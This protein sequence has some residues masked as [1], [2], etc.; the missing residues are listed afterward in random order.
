MMNTEMKLPTERVE[1]PSKGLI[2]SADNPLR[3]GFVD[4]KYMTAKEEDILTNMNLIENG[5]VLD[6]LLESLTMGKVDIKDLCTGDKN[7]LF[8]AS[9]ILGYGAK[10]KFQYDGDE[11]EVDL[12]KLNNKFINPDLLN[13]QGHFTF[14][15][16]HTQANITFRL[17]NDRDEKNINDEIESLKKL[18]TGGG[19]V[20]TRLRYQ[21]TSVNDK[22]DKGEIKQFIEN[23][24]LARDSQALREYMIEVN[25]DVD[26]KYTLDSGEVITIPISLG[27]I[28]PQTLSI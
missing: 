25:P 13:A 23:Y 2:Y 26:M 4:M 14:K 17:L 11:K 20:T 9:R 22:T 3:E 8:V 5:T 18:G 7:A 27:F 6:R 10:Y 1:L 15:L 12:S 16:P 28:F 19:S 21:I 24:L